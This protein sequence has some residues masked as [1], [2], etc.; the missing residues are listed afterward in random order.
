MGVDWL[1]K[2]WGRVNQSVSSAYCTNLVISD[3]SLPLFMFAQPSIRKIM[4]RCSE[5][6]EFT[7]AKYPE[8]LHGVTKKEFIIHANLS[9]CS[10]HIKKVS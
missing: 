2:G 4:H 3:K 5:N 10:P 9:I 7:S 1:G 6:W 8:N